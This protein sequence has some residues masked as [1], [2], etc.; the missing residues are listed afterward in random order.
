M[1]RTGRETEIEIGVTRTRTGVD[2]EA[3]SVESH[4]PAIEAAAAKEGRVPSAIEERGRRREAEEETGG[5]P[6]AAIA[7][8]IV[9][10]IIGETTTA[11]VDAVE[12][13]KE[14]IVIA[15]PLA[16]VTAEEAVGLEAAIEGA[17]E[18]GRAA[19][20]G[21]ANAK[22]AT[23]GILQSAKMTTAK[24]MMTK[25]TAAKTTTTA[26]VPSNRLVIR[27]RI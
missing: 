10:G 26:K 20:T 19:A 21:N 4:R 15:H 11:I 6:E 27:T 3:A 8:V 12:V 7:I 24:R 2:P 14:I 1:T 25:T 5:D 16:A 18:V 13:E 9:N 17:T 23:R 22:A